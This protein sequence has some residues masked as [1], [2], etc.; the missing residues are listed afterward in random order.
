MA[1]KLLKEARP[2]V[3]DETLEN[4]YLK[5]AQEQLRMFI[6]VIFPTALDFTVN[7]S[8]LAAMYRAAWS[9]AMRSVTQKMA[10][11]ICAKYPDIGFMFDPAVRRWYDW[12]ADFGR[13][14]VPGLKHEPSLELLELEGEASFR[15][16]SPETMHPLD[17]LHFSPEMMGNAPGSIL[18]GIEISLATMGQDQRHRTISRSKPVFTGK[19]YLPPILRQVD[20]LEGS[21]MELLEIWMSLQEN[22]PVSLFPLLAPYGAMVGYFKRGNLNAVLHEQAKRL[23]WCAQEEIYSLAVKLRRALLEKYGDV[24]FVA[25][26]EPPCFR[27][28]VCGEG[29]RYCGRDILARER[30]DEYFPER[31]V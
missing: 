28:G 18:T 15:I 7:L 8:T 30:G 27:A 16:P 17:L 20:G 9:P 3:P 12:G 4:I 29:K 5:I 6:P 31:K 23:C 25:S 11:L 22:L 26:L 21:A 14:S 19:F 1:K 10:D 24:P 13:L 2:L